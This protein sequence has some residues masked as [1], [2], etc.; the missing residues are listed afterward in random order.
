M[1]RKATAKSV[2]NFV[3]SVFVGPFE[4]AQP[5]LKLSMPTFGQSPNLIIFLCA[6][7]TLT[8]ILAPHATFF[9][10]LK[11]SRHGDGTVVDLVDYACLLLSSVCALALFSLVSIFCL[12]PAN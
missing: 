12:R 4:E 9:L 3:V 11:L 8:S 5:S 7:L 10:L 1:A 6:A 2:Q